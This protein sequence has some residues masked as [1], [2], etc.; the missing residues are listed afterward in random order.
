LFGLPCTRN[1]DSSENLQK[2]E[3]LQ[4]LP[5]LVPSLIQQQKKPSQ[6]TKHYKKTYSLTTHGHK[7]LDKNLETL[8]KAMPQQTLQRPT[9]SSSLHTNKS[10][11]NLATA[12]SPTP[13]LS[14]ITDHKKQS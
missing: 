5:S 9:S 8:P 4:E 13:E 6:N 12:S 3:E 11:P 10:M 2:E 1:C 7:N 14:K